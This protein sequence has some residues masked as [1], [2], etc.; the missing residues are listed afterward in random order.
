MKPTFP[1]I[2]LE[3]DAARTRMMTASDQLFPAQRR[4]R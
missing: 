2:S 3:A 1:G 4:Q